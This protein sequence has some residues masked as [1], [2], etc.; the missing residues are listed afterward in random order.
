[1]RLHH[2]FAKIIV[3]AFP[4]A[5]IADLCGSS[6]D[7]YTLKWQEE[8]DGSTVDTSIWNFRTDQKALMH[9]LP[10]MSKKEMTS[11]QST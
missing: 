8:F 3:A 9:S 10:Q 1:M 4:V 2:P 5:I 6:C 11:S 7:L